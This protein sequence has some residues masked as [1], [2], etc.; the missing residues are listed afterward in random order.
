MQI[1]AVVCLVC[2]I[3][4]EGHSWVEQLSIVT[5]GLLQT[6]RGQPVLHDIGEK[7]RSI[8]LAS[9]SGRVVLDVEFP[10]LNEILSDLY[11]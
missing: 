11:V 3:Q 6:P 8:D 2:M 1:L 7:S 9:C 5:D 4:T 10:T